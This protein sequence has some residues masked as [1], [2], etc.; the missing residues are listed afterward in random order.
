MNGASNALVTTPPDQFFLSPLQSDDNEHVNTLTKVPP[1][2]QPHIHKKYRRDEH[3]KISQQ[4]HHKQSPSGGDPPDERVGSNVS[5]SS[6]TSSAPSLV[7]Y[8]PRKYSQS[9][10]NPS[11]SRGVQQQQQ[12]Q[13][14]LLTP[15][16][17]GPTVAAATTSPAVRNGTTKSGASPN[18]KQKHP[19]N[20]PY[21]P[22]VHIT[23]KPPF[24]FST[25]IFLAIEYAPD[26]A[27]PVKEIYAW[28][29]RNFPY[30]K[31]APTGWKNSVRH[32]LS[33]NKCF[34]KV[35]KAPVS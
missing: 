11:D 15:T 23:N 34:Q 25:L 9:K 32:N 27:L 33:L 30:F 24:S 3:V 20:Q 29:M 21:N 35:E 31:T 5:N 1:V 26:K 18:S 16:N 19:N 17:S 4:H 14:L 12:Q 28:M 2:K 8:S 7:S 22:L 13:A 6:N 10:H